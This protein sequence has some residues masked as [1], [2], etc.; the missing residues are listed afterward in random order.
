MS[1]TLSHLK[2]VHG[3]FRGLRWCVFLD[4]EY[5]FKCS[6]IIF[7]QRGKRVSLKND[8][9]MKVQDLL[10]C[11]PFH[12]FLVGFEQASLMKCLMAVSN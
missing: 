4:F 6:V 5:V 1:C 3:N 7:R 12:V 10:L 11:I 2:C 9:S 8:V